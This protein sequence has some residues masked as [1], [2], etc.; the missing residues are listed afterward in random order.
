MKFVAKCGKVLA[1]VFLMLAIALYGLPLANTAHAQVEP[2]PQRPSRDSGG[3]SGGPSHGG[4]GPEGNPVLEAGE[5]FLQVEVGQYVAIPLIV[6]NFRG[7]SENVQVQAT[8]PPFLQLQQCAQ[9][10]WGTY[11]TT[12]SWGTAHVMMG[13]RL[14]VDI[15]DLF[16]SDVVLIHAVVKV[17]A[18]MSAPNNY[19]EA[20]LSSESDRDLLADN[21]AA[22]GFGMRAQ[23]AT[24]QMTQQPG[25]VTL[26]VTEGGQPAMLRTALSS[27]PATDVVVYFETDSQIAPIQPVVFTPQNWNIIQMVPVS[28]VDDAH[29]EGTHAG[30]VRYRFE[31]VDPNYN[32]LVMPDAVVQILDNDQAGV[33]LAP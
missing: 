6:T 32:A 23:V 24:Q 25:S 1:G 22:V 16:E 17:V 11:C 20:S 30:I 27:Q 33:I 15:G 29:A 21:Y 28:A 2:P 12:T 18:P 19:M 7:K 26:T 3:D 9:D 8:L 4:G 14:L 13:N 10:Q 5:S 31:S